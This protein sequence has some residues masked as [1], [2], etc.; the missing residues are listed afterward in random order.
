MKGA[1]ALT[2]ILVTGA[3]APAKAPL[4]AMMKGIEAAV[5]V[6]VVVVVVA[7]EKIVLVV[8]KAV[9][10]VAVGGNAPVTTQK[11]T[12]ESKRLRLQRV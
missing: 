5:V 4:R 11:I 8:A 7:A 2:Y 6:V 3:L 12:I 9:V 1:A 10:V